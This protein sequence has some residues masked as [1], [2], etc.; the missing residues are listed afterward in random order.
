MILAAFI[1]MVYII[2]NYYCIVLYLYCIII[3][4][5]LHLSGDPVPSFFYSILKCLL[6]ASQQ[7]TISW[8]LPPS[9]IFKVRKEG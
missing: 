2:C 4:F 7:S 9:Y 6:R 1:S 5:S 3:V 8:I